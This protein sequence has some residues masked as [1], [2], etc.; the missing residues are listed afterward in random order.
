MSFD[1]SSLRR[2]GDYYATE[3]PDWVRNIWKRPEGFDWFIKNNRTQLSDAGAIVRIGRD[4]FVDV[5]QFPMAATKV[6]GI[7]V[8]V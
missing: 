6:M 4:W 3:A 5:D 2:K 7:E 8:A 1:L